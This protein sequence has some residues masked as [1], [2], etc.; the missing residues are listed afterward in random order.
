MAAGTTRFIPVLHAATTSRP[1]E[2]DTLVAANAVAAALK[3]LG[4]STEIIGLASDFAEVEALSA[5]RPLLVFNLVD[6]VDGDG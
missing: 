2:I 6:A 1:D 5:S 3:E 4:Y